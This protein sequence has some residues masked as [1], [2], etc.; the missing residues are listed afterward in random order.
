MGYDNAG[1]DARVLEAEVT[2]NA[3]DKTF[4]DLFMNATVALFRTDPTNGRILECNDLF[5]DWLG[6]PSRDACLAECVT[7]DHYENP[8]DRERILATLTSDGTVMGRPVR[9]KRLDGSMLWVDISAALDPES[10]LV[11]GAM[12]DISNYKALQETL[13]DRVEARSRELA[14]SSQMLRLVMDNIPQ[15]IF[16]KDRDSVFQGCNRRFA[17][18]AGF[19][20][21]AELVGLTD[22]DL[23]W[24]DEEADWYL[25]MDQMVMTSKSPQTNIIETQRQADGRQAWL[26][27]N[28]MPLLDESGEVIGILGTFEDITERKRREEELRKL[29]NYD[30]L[31]GL[32][33]RKL[34]KERLG[35]AI[36]AGREEKVGHA[37]ILIDVDHF[38]TINDSLGHHFG[39][40]LLVAFGHRLRQTVPLEHLVARLGGD[41]F[42]V[43]L[44]GNHGPDEVAAFAEA[45]MTALVQACFLDGHEIVVTPSIG[46]ALY[47]EHGH[48]GRDLMRHADA[49]LF[50][51]KGLGRNNFQFFHPEMGR[52][53]K[54]RL[55][56]EKRLRRALDGDE[57]TVF[58]QPKIDV[59][60]GVLTGLEALARWQ[61]PEHGLVT[62][63]SFI[64]FAEETGQIVPLADIILEKACTHAGAWL[65]AGYDFGRLAVNLSPL[66]FRHGD[67]LSRILAILSKTG[68]PADR[69][70]LEITESALINDSGHAMSLMEEIREAGISLA[71][72]DFGTG[73]SSLSSLKHYPLNTLKIDRSFITDIASST[74]DRNIAASIVGLGHYLGLEVVAEGVENREQVGI[75][76][77]LRCHHMQGFYF[78]EPLP[79]TELTVVLEKQTRAMNKSKD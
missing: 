8:V 20:D 72:D 32:A 36:E 79:D 64:A 78:S 18:A 35:H 59:R 49:A 14:T 63:D 7:I 16:W 44:E 41:E 3:F 48:S 13:E 15:A 26:D 70:E 29:T 10:G 31:T 33:N 56:L 74:K 58:F 9:I 30:V 57:M 2:G 43:L 46:I 60:S 17:E 6:Y 53:A 27:T 75:L 5:A 62:P 42:G 67:L 55:E 47:P 77:G 69:L 51:A 52:R 40:R 19:E 73:Y 37:L 76:R 54:R 22:R 45:L 28:K 24:L 71:L 39:D 23:P 34:F 50:H 12:V 68:F 25:E 66:Q 65:D 1:D 21:P 11:E 4:R 38:K 61:D